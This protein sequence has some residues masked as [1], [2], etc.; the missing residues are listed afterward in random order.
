MH[1]MIYR[2]RPDVN[3]VV[4]AHPLY[5]TSFAAAGKGLEIPILPEAVIHLGKIY[6]VEYGT[7]CTKELSDAVEK[8]VQL[9]DALLLENHGALTYGDT[10]I[11]AYHNMESM[12]FY[13]HVLFNTYFLGGPKEIKGENIEKLYEV[14]RRVSILKAVIPQ[15]NKVKMLGAARKNEILNILQNEKSVSVNM[16]SR[17]FNVSEETVR[18]DLQKLEKEGYI[19]KTHGGAMVKEE[20]RLTFLLRYAK[21]KNPIGKS[22]LP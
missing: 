7:P 6:L 9:T 8:Y 18:R 10:L 5:A 13:A 12:E 1:M 22:A 20:N 4:H 11:N 14:R 15:T 16:L 3:A 21:N 19:I 17:R 2:N